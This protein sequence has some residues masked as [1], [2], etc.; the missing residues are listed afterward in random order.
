MQ[1]RPNIVLGFLAFL[2]CVIPY[3]N[4]AKASTTLY[5]VILEV[6]ADSTGKVTALHVSKVIDP[7]SGNTKPVPVKIPDSY[8]SAVQKLL[9]SKT[10]LA[11]G[12]SYTYAFYDPA[13]PDRADIDPHRR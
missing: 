2:F 1:P 3:Y 12:I 7:S 5:A 9:L 8:M 13:Q 4:L 11:N 6:T 10:Y